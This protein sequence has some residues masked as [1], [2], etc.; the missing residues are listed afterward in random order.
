MSVKTGS[1]VV[2]TLSAKTSVAQRT[3]SFK[4][5]FERAIERFDGRCY[6]DRIA[7]S[8]EGGLEIQLA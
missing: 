5:S 8:I 2:R 6:L 3:N 7:I 1:V 4:V